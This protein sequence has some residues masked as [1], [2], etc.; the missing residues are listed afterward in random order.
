MGTSPVDRAITVAVVEDIDVV[1]EG[2]RSWVAED[3]DQR[4]RIVPDGDRIGLDPVEH[5]VATDPKPAKVRGSEGEG[6]RRSGIISKAVDGVQD[7]A[8]PVRVVGEEAG[9]SVDRLLLE[10]DLVG[11]R[12][13]PSR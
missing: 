2:V 13:R 12:S 11:H 9:C 4:A 8:E 6:L 10:G 3:P 1:A 7:V 5:P